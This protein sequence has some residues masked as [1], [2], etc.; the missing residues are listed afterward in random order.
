M[1]IEHAVLAQ[2]QR[3]LNTRNGCRTV[4]QASPIRVAALSY[5]YV[6]ARVA[7][8]AVGFP[9]SQYVPNFE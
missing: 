1:I 5:V 4:L 8:I 6:G 2:C 3:Q 9:F 7:S